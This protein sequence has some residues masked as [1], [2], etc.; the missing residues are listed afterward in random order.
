[1]AEAEGSNP[2]I[3]T[4]TTQDI[5]EQIDH[6]RVYDPAIAQA[7]TQTAREILAELMNRLESCNEDTGPQGEM[8]S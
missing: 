4:N 1:M 2:S 8:Q 6:Y 3:Q 7:I 5:M